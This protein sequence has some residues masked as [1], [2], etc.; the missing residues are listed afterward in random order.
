MPDIRDGH[1]NLDVGMD[2][3][4]RGYED[5][6]DVEEP[7]MPTLAAAR[8]FSASI[9]VGLFV[10]LGGFV[11]FILAVF[12]FV[13]SPRQ[14]LAAG[15]REL[16]I[17]Q[18]SGTVKSGEGREVLDRA[19]R[20]LQGI[21]AGPQAARNIAD[22]LTIIAVRFERLRNKRIDEAPETIDQPYG[23][24]FDLTRAD[25]SAAVTL[26][27]QSVDWKVTPPKIAAAHASF[28]IE[29]SA[30]PVYN[31]I[32][33]GALAGYR[34]SNGGFPPVA[35]PLD[36]WNTDRQ[37]AMTLCRSLDTW[38]K[39]FGIERSGLSYMLIE[40]P[41]RIWFD[42]RGWSSDGMTVVSLDRDEVLTMCR[43]AYTW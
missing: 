33:K 42:G 24:D 1:S 14:E 4:R 34:L 5:R 20:G 41:T 2:F 12:A 35:T 11:L 32:P 17:E 23:V 26:T 40:D 25:R 43:E 30:A 28:A 16:E 37:S 13:S 9:R 38:A 31:R 39:Y 19:S 6:F 3:G 10:V 29:T 7:P 22:R 18:R 15:L 27:D 21:S 8:T 36:P